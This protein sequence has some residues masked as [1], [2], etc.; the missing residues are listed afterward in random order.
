VQ[1]LEESNRALQREL[2]LHQQSGG[3]HGL[4]STNAQLR[5]KLTAA[6]TMLRAC[7][8]FHASAGHSSEHGGSSGRGPVAPDVDAFA[9]SCVAIG[10]MDH[11]L[12]QQAGEQRRAGADPPAS[13]EQPGIG[14]KPPAAGAQ[15][16]SVEAPQGEVGAHL[17]SRRVQGSCAGL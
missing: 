16:G 14:T 6:L 12:S 7:Q 11:H 13:G 2:E 8:R 10:I 4:A 3:M 9:S 5:A 1:T 15:F 17:Q